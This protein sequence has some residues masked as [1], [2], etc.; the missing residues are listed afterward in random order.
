VRYIIEVD[1]CADTLRDT[2]VLVNFPD[3]G[4]TGV[5]TLYCGGG[6][7]VTVIP[8]TNPGTL[9]FDGVN[10]GGL[11]FALPTVS[12]LYPVRHILVEN[13][14]ADTADT[15]LR[16]RP[17]PDS[18]FSGL[19][20]SYCNTGANV[21]LSP[22]DPTGQFALDGGVFPGNSFTLPTTAGAYTLTHIV[23]LN[24]C[25]DTTDS[26][27]NVFDFPDPSFTG[28]DSL[29]CGGG[30]TVNLTPAV[31]GG[32]FFVQ[33]N[34]IAGTSF[35]TPTTQGVYQ[36]RHIATQNGCNDTLDTTFT[37]QTQPDADFAGLNNAYCNRA[38]NIVLAPNEG[39]GQFALDGVDF[40]G[41][42]FAMPTTPG[43]YE[44]R[45]VVTWAAVATPSARRSP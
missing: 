14:C 5:D 22:N 28:L 21:T 32:Q 18:E 45:H 11:T 42:S 35:T 33:F 3:A 9:F 17:I 25:S 40:P 44:L 6:Q 20:A 12:G 4:F 37:V 24:G 23:E 38:Q 36:F 30:Q 29:Y 43:V 2:F 39:G 41:T 8:N 16:I 26:V 34:P 1:N 15:N 19:E 13:G 10:Q 31:P 27:F 7:S